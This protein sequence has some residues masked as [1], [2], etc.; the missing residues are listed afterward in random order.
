M[1]FSFVDLIC[2]KTKTTEVGHVIQI[3]LKAENR[4]ILL[5]YDCFMDYKHSTHSI[6]EL[7]TLRE[8]AEGSY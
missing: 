6:Y 4:I 5:Q 8:K 7:K 1:A 3:N 2:W